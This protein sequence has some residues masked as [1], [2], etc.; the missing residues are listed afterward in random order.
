MEIGTGVLG[1]AVS[2]TE[3]LSLS[4][5]ILLATGDVTGKCGT[6]AR[7]TNVSGSEVVDIAGC[8]SGCI[9]PGCFWKV[10]QVL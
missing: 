5:G 1:L 4:E 2:V 8:N 10:Y 6:V 7:S 3:E 9:F